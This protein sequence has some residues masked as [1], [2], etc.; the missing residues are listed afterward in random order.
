MTVGTLLISFLIT[1][2][3][4]ISIGFIIFAV[5]MK[6]FKMVCRRKSNRNQI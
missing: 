5:I 2:G 4:P 1:M 3:F 6:L